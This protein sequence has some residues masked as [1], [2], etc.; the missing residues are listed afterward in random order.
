MI[1]ANLAEYVDT[2]QGP[3]AGYLAIAVSLFNLLVS[4]RNKAELRWQ[5][6]FSPLIAASCTAGLAVVQKVSS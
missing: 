4:A 1:L 6:L 5:Y 2:D 3:I